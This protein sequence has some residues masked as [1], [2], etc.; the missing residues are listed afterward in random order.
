MWWL[1]LAICLASAHGQISDS[2][3]P[4]RSTWNRYNDNQERDQST[5]F[6]YRNGVQTENVIITEA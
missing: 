2:V 5:G 6:G 4:T 1:T 3:D